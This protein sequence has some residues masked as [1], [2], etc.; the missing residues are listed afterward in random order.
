MCLKDEVKRVRNSMNITL[1]SLND[2]SPNLY[3]DSTD[4]KITMPYYPNIH[5]YK[6]AMIQVKSV[7]TPPLQH[8][9]K[10]E[11]ESIAY[12]IE[13]DGIGVNNSYISGSSS[14]LIKVCLDNGTGIAVSEKATVA[15]GLSDQHPKVHTP[16]E[17]W[18]VDDEFYILPQRHQNGGDG[19]GSFVGDLASTR[20]A[21]LD[22]A[23][24]QSHVL[25]DFSPTNDLDKVI[26]GTKLQE[27]ILRYS[28]QLAVGKVLTIT[29]ITTVG[30]RDRPPTKP[31][32]HAGPVTTWKLVSPGS[33]Y[34]VTPVPADGFMCVWKGWK[35]KVGGTHIKHQ[36]TS[37]RYG[38][39]ENINGHADSYFYDNKFFTEQSALGAAHQNR[40]RIPAGLAVI[41]GHHNMTA[42]GV[43]AT[44]AGF[45][46]PD[47]FFDDAVMCA[48]P[49][50]KQLHV[51]LINVMKPTEHRT[52]SKTLHGAADPQLPPTVRYDT[53]GECIKNETSGLVMD[54]TK[55]VVVNVRVMLIDPE[56]MTPG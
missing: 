37:L 55:P 15:A 33:I 34:K 56:D 54:I 11:L 6:Q 30:N 23:M 22:L 44:S 16:G 1:S 8:S 24:A 48:N 2:E 45:M 14:S 20:A 32:L 40:N 42:A 28:K 13:I 43:A 35:G 21:V 7:I 31:G 9:G 4:F 27:Y 52:D 36:V 12:G 53:V 49:F 46:N 39:G 17:E 26:D 5:N 51:R 19:I 25:P 47:G 38:A 41:T 10:D 29:K 18:M 3:S 50:G